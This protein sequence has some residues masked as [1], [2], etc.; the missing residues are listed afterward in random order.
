MACAALWTSP[1]AAQ[2]LFEWPDTAVD[3]SRYTT[4]EECAAAVH[5]SVETSRSLEMLA[6]GIWMDTVPYD[7]AEA[8]EPVA[9]AVGETSRRCLWRFASPDSVPIRDQLFLLPLYLSAGWDDKALALAE[10]RLA[11]VAPDAEG[12]LEAVIDTVLRVYGG[13]WSYRLPPRVDL[14]DAFAAVHLPRVKDRV[15]RLRLY[16]RVLNA[17]QRPERFDTARVERELARAL[18][19]ADSLTERE[20]EGFTESDDVAALF[21]DGADIGERIAGHEQFAFFRFAA[22]DSLR[23]ST[24][25]YARAM[26][27][28]WR[29]AT[30]QPPGTLMLGTPIGE[31]APTLEGDI[32]LG[33]R[34]A[35][36]PRPAPGRVSLVLILRF[37]SF[38]GG[39]CGFVLDNVVESMYGNCA[40]QMYA[41][42]RLIERFP[43]L[44]VTIVARTYGHFKYVKADPAEEAELMRKW[45]DAYGIRAAFTVTETDFWRLPNHDGRRIEEETANVEN[46]SFGGS[47]KNESPA[48]LIDEDGII[49]HTWNFGRQKEREFA[50][51]IE[52]LLE[53]KRTRT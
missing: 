3:V 31:R 49:V 48:F 17:G 20:R 52:I 39:D 30:G 33:C 45:L 5:R 28:L 47:W 26:R 15:K 7:P 34:E 43:E 53:R 19:L 6:S 24:E 11:A 9:A 37:G 10:R 13:D 23:R 12:E 50:D 35:C 46:Y 2:T 14:V 36:G 51:L 4:V 18:A 1:A 27:E 42:R 8:P 38:Y 21:T 29:R 22:R 40:E 32:W 25:A 41:L 16:L 44:D